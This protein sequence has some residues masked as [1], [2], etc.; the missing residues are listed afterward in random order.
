M[1]GKGKPKKKTGKSDWWC[2]PP[3]IRDPLEQ[4][5]SGPV[6]VDPCSNDRSIIKAHEARTF[7]GLV[8]PWWRNGT[9]GTVYQNDPYS[10]AGVWT[11]K[12]L[13]EIGSGRVTE[14]VRLSMM[15]TSAR[16]WG[17]M[18]SYPARN[19]RILG[20]KRIKFLDPDSPQAGMRRMTCRF[21]PALTYFGPRI[22][23]FTKAFAHLTR[24]ATW[25]R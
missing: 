6:D 22:D 24:W 10:K 17:D 7:G 14:L 1:A 8:L 20:L 25:G 19:P 2:S 16:W 18:C 21:E 5:F 13:L 11:E 12:M 23:E 9:P 15:S 3:E 4:F